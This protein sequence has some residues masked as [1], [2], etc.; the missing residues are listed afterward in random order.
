[1]SVVVN[2][3][4]GIDSIW[5]YLEWVEHL[6]RKIICTILLIYFKAITAKIKLIIGENFFI[7]TNLIRFS[8]VLNREALHCEAEAYLY[9]K[10]YFTTVVVKSFC[11]IS[12]LNCCLCR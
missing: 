4:R 5:V 8:S 12:F 9:N 7:S 1:M 2:Y 3:L 11:T 10:Q 6:T